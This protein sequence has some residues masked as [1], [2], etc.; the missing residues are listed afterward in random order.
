MCCSSWSVV[1]LGTSRPRL[2]P[3]RVDGCIDNVSQYIRSPVSHTVAS[4]HREKHAMPTHARTDGDPPNEAA[5]GDGRVDDRD[6]VCQLL[7]K[8]TVEV[9]APAQGRQAVAVDLIK[10]RDI[11]H[12]GD[13]THGHAGPRQGNKPAYAT[14]HTP[15]HLLVSRAKTP[16]SL[17]FSNCRRV[18]MVH[19]PCSS[20]VLLL[21]VLLP[22]MVHWYTCCSPLKSNRRR[23]SHPRGF[24]L[25]ALIKSK[26]F[27]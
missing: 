1:V 8:H 23:P 12:L 24:D 17:L 27:A 16:I 19:N 5:A 18:A 6:V 13:I 21:M 7:L 4:M 11:W 9:L 25:S 22:C 15:S 2:L 14:P 3:A 26:T 20:W 10:G